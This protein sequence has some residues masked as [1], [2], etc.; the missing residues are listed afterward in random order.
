MPETASVT[1]PASK[2]SGDGRLSRDSATPSR[3]SLTH[4]G[5]RR[6]RAGISPT[7]G[8]V[9]EGTVRRDAGGLVRLDRPRA[10][11]LRN[12]GCRPRRQRP[13]A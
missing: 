11:V 1:T 6:A 5:P 7:G 3:R 12:V 10:L 2:S 13:G 9:V 4:V 8:S